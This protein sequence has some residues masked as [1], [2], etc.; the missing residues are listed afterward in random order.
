M[1]ALPA[2][3]GGPINLGNPNEFTIKDLAELVIKKVYGGNELSLAIDKM[4]VDRPMPVDDPTQ[5]CPDINRAL[6]LLGWEPT[7][8]LADGLD[9]TIAYFR[10]ALKHR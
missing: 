7:V 4:I 10:E 8:Q 2:N 6:E 9:K 5:R 3:P 1:G